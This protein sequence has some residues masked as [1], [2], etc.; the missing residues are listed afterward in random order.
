MDLN[1]DLIQE[2]F[3]DIQ[4][5]LVRLEKISALPREAFLADQ[6]VL[7]LACYRLLVAIEAAL[8]ICFHVSAKRCH[9]VPD[10]YAECFAILGEA[11]VLTPELSRNLQRMARFRN[12]L[13]HTYWKVD[14]GQVYATLQSGLEDLKAFIRAIGAL[15]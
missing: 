15:L 8:Q 4:Q 9:R 5:S 14:Y 6:D 11:G 10:Q 2:R 1:K 12:M 13:V 3:Q 7:D